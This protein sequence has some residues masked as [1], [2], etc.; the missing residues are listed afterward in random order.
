MASENKYQQAIV[1]ITKEQEK[2]IG[3]NL[4]KQLI[5]GVASLKFDNA[6]EPILEE[7]ADPK[8]ILGDLVD[9]YASLFGRASV[10]VSREAI[11]N[12]SSSNVSFSANELPDNLR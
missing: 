2:I 6:G 5:N 9:Q 8:K 1:V 10:E 3:H 12:L 7:G 4:A 11:Q